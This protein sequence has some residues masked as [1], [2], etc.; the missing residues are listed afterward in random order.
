[1]SIGDGWL[2]S[3]IY[4]VILV[5]E[6]KERDMKNK[7]IV[8]MMGL[9]V[10]GSVVAQSSS[11]RKTGETQQSTYYLNTATYEFSRL[12]IGKSIFGVVIQQNNKS[13][14]IVSYM[15]EYVIE[16]DCRKGYGQMNVY[17]LRDNFMENVSWVRNSGTV[18]DSI[19][20]NLCY[21]AGWDK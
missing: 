14:N 20:R 10:C 2:T 9:L 21:V 15:K 3:R 16:E 7:I 4:L 8:L 12:M 13:T 17:D 1:M 6:I 18:S 5:N 11:L 19:S